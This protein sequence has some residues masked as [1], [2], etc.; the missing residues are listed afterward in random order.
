MIIDVPPELAARIR[1]LSELLPLQGSLRQVD[2]ERAVGVEILKEG[3][4]HLEAIV[5]AQVTLQGE[6]S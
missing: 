2:C 3:L 5:G 4:R 6:L 1:H